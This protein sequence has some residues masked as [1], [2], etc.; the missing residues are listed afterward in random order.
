[1]KKEKE[2][3]RNYPGPF[4]YAEPRNTPVNGQMHGSGRQL[5]QNQEPET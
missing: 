2:K 3:T 5:D 4:C 1:M